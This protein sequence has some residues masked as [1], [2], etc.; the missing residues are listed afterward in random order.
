MVDPSAQLEISVIQKVMAIPHGSDPLI[1]LSRLFESIDRIVEHIGTQIEAAF[2]G[3]SDPLL[4]TGDQRMRCIEIIKSRQRISVVA[5]FMEP[6]QLKLHVLFPVSDELPHEQIPLSLALRDL[7]HIS[8]HTLILLLKPERSI[9]PTFTISA[10]EAVFGHVLSE[11][12]IAP[13]VAFT[14]G[15]PIDE[16]VFGLGASPLQPMD[17]C[18]GSPCC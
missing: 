11:I 3:E 1:S 6:G 4:Q 18:S 13:L 5:I 8:G 10:A 17:P 15:I 14:P 7:L 12:R 9:Q 16:I 2:L